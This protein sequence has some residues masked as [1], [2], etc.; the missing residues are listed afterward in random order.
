MLLP[1]SQGPIR[2]GLACQGKQSGTWGPLAERYSPSPV[3]CWLQ[4]PRVEPCMLFLLQEGPRQWPA[5]TW[6]SLSLQP[7]LWDPSFGRQA[8]QP[9]SR[10]HYWYVALKQLPELVWAAVVLILRWEARKTGH[11]RMVR[12]QTPGR[13]AWGF[14][15]WL[16]TLIQFNWLSLS[17]HLLCARHYARHF[18]ESVRINKMWSL[19]GC[20]PWGMTI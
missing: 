4:L 3:A 16:W 13:P 19:L 18:R 20:R 8:W 6:R 1:G 7:S 10:R 11:S 14:T 15:V 2:L 12:G 9:F 17:R 5:R